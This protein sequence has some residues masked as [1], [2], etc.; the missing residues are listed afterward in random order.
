MPRLLL[1]LLWGLALVLPAH[2]ADHT[3][4]V[5]GLTL[6]YQ[7]HGTGEPL[8][9]LHGF[10]GCGNDWADFVPAL[11]AHYQLII[12]DLRGHGGSSN[13]S[14]KF[15]MRDSASDLLVL[16]DALKLKRVRAMGISAGGMTL[17]HAATREPARFQSLVLIGATTH[18]PAQARAI[19]ASVPEGVPPP[20]MDQFHACATR[21]RAQVDA[22]MQQFHGF[23]DS[24]D[25]MTFTAPTLGT[26]IARTL[27]VMGDRDEFF[28]VQI[29][30]D[31]YAAI[32]GSA[33]W[34]VPGGDHVPIYGPVQ[35]E[36]E[37]IALAWLATPAP[38]TP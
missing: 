9:L 3:A 19:M 15:S 38:R 21:G 17:M 22:L 10:G 31:M 25:D 35:P 13:P 11:S 18:F 30:A 14:G 24:Y 2:A 27:V 8:V 28:P 23:K 4:K 36:F 1:I 37:R 6:H 26:I 33:L 12:P 20:V 34:V 29:A 16:L 7:T 32:P 5:N